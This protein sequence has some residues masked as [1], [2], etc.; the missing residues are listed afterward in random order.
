MENSSEQGGMNRNAAV[1]I[2]KRYAWRVR[3]VLDADAKVYLI[4]WLCV[5]TCVQN[6]GHILYFLD[7]YIRKNVESF[8]RSKA[9]ANN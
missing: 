1:E 7:T 6:T 9:C 8:M 2:A 3:N 4:W 5:R